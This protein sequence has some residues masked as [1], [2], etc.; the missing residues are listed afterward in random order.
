MSEEKANQKERLK[1]PMERI[2][3]Y[4]PKSYTNAQ[5]EEDIVKMCEAR[6]RKRA[7]RDSR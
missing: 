4:F 3:K 6:F 7:D 1:I 2:R 5:M